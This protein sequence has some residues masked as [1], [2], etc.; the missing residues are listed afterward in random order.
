MQVRSQWPRSAA[1]SPPRPGIH[2]SRWRADWPRLRRQCPR[3]SRRR[4]CPPRGRAKLALRC[5]ALASCGSSADV[6]GAARGQRRRAA[7]VQRAAGIVVRSARAP[8]CNRRCSCSACSQ[9]R[10]AAVVTAE[11]PVS[12]QL[13]SVLRSTPRRRSEAEL[14][15]SVQLF[16]VPP[17]APPPHGSRVARQRA[18]V[19]RAAT[20]RPAAGNQSRVARQRAVVQRAVRPPRR[21]CRQPSCRSAC[22]CSVHASRRPA[23]KIEPSCR[24]AC[25]CSA[26][27]YTRRRM[28]PSCRSA[29]SCSA[30]P[31]IAPP[32][33]RAELPVS[34]QL[35]TTALADSHHT[36]PPLFSRRNR[37]PPAWPRWSA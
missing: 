10:P 16:S 32:P 33:V 6:A 31:K 20:G 27:R 12:V 30:W 35:V 17:Y 13:F 37:R 19:Q 23:A 1:R 8:C 18:V 34:V 14:P 28:E 15:V 2:R 7:V 4:R 3:R 21:R 24:S 5:E 25:S 29:C 36:P 22:S 26:C 11:L 9:V